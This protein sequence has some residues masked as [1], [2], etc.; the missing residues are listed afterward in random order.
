VYAAELGASPALAGCQL[1]LA[2][3]ALAAG[4]LSAGWL[5]DRL[6]CRKTLIFVGGLVGMPALWLMGQ[7]G[8]IWM[9]AVVSAAWYF[10]VTSFLV[11]ISFITGAIGNALVTDLVP[12]QALGRALSLFGTPSWIAGILGCAGAG[13]ALQRLG[14]ALTFGA[15][16]LLPLVA[17]TL[18]IGTHR[19][20]PQE[21]SPLLPTGQTAFGKLRFAGAG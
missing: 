19:A 15:A 3:A 13:Y 12:Q 4:T 18:L 1:S 10:W 2:Y 8:D 5:S 6:Q 7:V 16:A 21:K 14:L 9:L 17:I 11:T 20:R